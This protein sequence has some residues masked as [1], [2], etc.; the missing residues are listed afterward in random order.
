MRMMMMKKLKK[1]LKKKKYKLCIIN[2]RF[3]RW[4]RGKEKATLRRKTREEQL[5]CLQ[6]N[7][8]GGNQMGATD[9]DG[10]HQKRGQ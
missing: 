3:E 9:V 1:K 2:C 5:E 6:V 7:I 4:C 10:L 8:N